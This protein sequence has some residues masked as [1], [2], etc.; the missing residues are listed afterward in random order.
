MER[1]SIKYFI[2]SYADSVKKLFISS[3]GFEEIS[4]Q[5]PYPTLRHSTGYYFN[6]EKGR[7]LKEFQ[8]VYIT[9][10]EGVLETRSGGLFP[11]SGEWFLFYFQESGI[12]ITLII[13]LVGVIIGLVLMVQILR[14]G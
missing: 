3:V 4:A 11:L 7:I 9:E 12:P 2:D 5:S 8:L 6:P 10:G 14:V 13:K 1:T